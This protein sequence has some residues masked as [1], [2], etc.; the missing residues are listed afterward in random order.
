[1]VKLSRSSES[2]FS[3]ST[4]YSFENQVDSTDKTLLITREEEKPGIDISIS[5]GTGSST[6]EVFEF[7]PGEG[8]EAGKHI[9]K[10]KETAAGLVYIDRDGILQ[11]LPW[12]AIP[13]VLTVSGDELEWFPVSAPDKDFLLGMNKQGEWE[14]FETIRCENNCE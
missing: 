13:S 4:E 1:M 7:S 9:L 10:I 6:E 5:I 3:V 12:P 11:C 2:G 14:W 8:E